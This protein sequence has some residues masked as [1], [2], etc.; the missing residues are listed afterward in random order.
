MPNPL[1]KILF[2]L[3]NNFKKISRSKEAK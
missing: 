2:L 1:E 3:Y